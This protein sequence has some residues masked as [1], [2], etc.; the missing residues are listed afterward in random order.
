MGIVGWLQLHGENEKEKREVVFSEDFKVE[1]HRYDRGLPPT[2][3]GPTSDTHF[4]PHM[5]P[6]PPQF[7]QQQQ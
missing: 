2:V 5:S 4:R 1:G 7:K 6:L 3:S